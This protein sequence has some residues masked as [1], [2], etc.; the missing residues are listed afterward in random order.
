MAKEIEKISSKITPKRTA[1][2]VGML[3]VLASPAAYSAG[4]YTESTHQQELAVSARKAGD[5]HKAKQ[6]E[7]R[8]DNLD[9]KAD[10]VV[11]IM[12]GA[13]YG[14]TAG[15]ALVAAGLAG[16]VQYRRRQASLEPHEQ[17]IVATGPPQE[18]SPEELY[19]ALA[20]NEARPL[21]PV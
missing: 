6:W 19:D 11:S 15:F 9:Q 12:Q 17:P 10:R 3:A 1:A 21:Q 2:A 18:P 13:S 16:S 5:F 8:A 20:G 14:G 4:A 7:A